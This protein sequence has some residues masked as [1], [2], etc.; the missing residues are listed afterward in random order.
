ML[1]SISTLYH[2]IDGLIYHIAAILKL[3]PGGDVCACM[4][5]SLIDGYGC[6]H[7]CG[8]DQATTHYVINEIKS[9]NLSVNYEQNGF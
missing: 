4:Y 7:G 2:S 5:D 6:I 9:H 8:L 1:R 3:P